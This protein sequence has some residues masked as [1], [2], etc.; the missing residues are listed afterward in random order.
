MESLAWA[1]IA[2]K[3]QSWDL[4]PNNT[5]PGIWHFPTKLLLQP[6]LLS[7]VLV[8]DWKHG[9]LFRMLKALGHVKRA[10]SYLLGQAGNKQTFPTSKGRT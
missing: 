3:W 2:G 7:S 6:S 8:K 1:H 4:N 10:T 9:W 5:L